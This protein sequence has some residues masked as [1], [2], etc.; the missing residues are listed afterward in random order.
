MEI[1]LADMMKS[2]G[3]K[4]NIIPKSDDKFNFFIGLEC[5]RAWSGNMLW[6]KKIVSYMNTKI[7]WGK[8]L[9]FGNFIR[10]S[11]RSTIKTISSVQLAGDAYFLLSN[12]LSS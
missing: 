5:I 4:G 10:N 9:D 7:L 6:K 12:I 8:F 11:S 2:I 1:I 3:N